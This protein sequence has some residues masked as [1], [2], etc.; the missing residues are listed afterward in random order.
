[1]DLPAISPFVERHQ[2]LAVR[3]P[4][5]DPGA[6][7]R[8]AGGERQ[9]VR[10]S[11][12]RPGNLSEDLPGLF[13]RAAQATF[14]DVFGVRIGQGALMNMLRRAQ[15]CFVSGREQAVAELRQAKVVSADETG[16]RIEEATPTTGSSAAARPWSIKPP[17][18][19]GPW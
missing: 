3:C 7:R 18:R 14:A 8:A 5:C 6:R 1:M 19:A 9:P 13:L 16:V 12:A 4:A 2:R 11:P 17:P 10:A 15:D